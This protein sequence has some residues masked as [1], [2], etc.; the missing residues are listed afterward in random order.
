M[1]GGADSPAEIIRLAWDESRGL[2]FTGLFHGQVQTWNLA[3]HHKVA[4]FQPAQVDLLDMRLNPKS[5]ELVIGA[6]AN[7]AGFVPPQGGPMIN[8]RDNPATLV[9]AWD[10]RDGKQIRVYAGPG[11]S[12]TAVRISTDGKLTAAV[13]SRMIASRTPS[14]LIL[15]DAESGAIVKQ[16]DLGRGSV[17]DLDFSPDNRELA[18]SVDNSV[19]FIEIDP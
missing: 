16:I 7:L 19:H 14:Y 4:D 11:G 9:Q 1:F 6:S 13:K 18:Y 15:W 10:G 2:L 3:S 5:S 8:L 12:A 17:S